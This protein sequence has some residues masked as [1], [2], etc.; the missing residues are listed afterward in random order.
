MEVTD[1]SR[2]YGWWLNSDILKKVTK[3]EKKNSTYIWHF[4]ALYNTN[5]KS[6][7]SDKDTEFKL[8]IILIVMNN[9]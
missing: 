5:S 2:H 1:P 3:F 8:Y 4:W 7:H 6:P 9:F